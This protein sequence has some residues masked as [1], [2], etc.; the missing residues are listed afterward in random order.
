MSMILTKGILFMV[1]RY[2]F[3]LKYNKNEVPG[4]LENRLKW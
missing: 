3:L 4:C 1:Q 2:T